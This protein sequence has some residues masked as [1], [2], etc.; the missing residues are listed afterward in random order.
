[1]KPITEEQ[2][3]FLVLFVMDGEYNLQRTCN[4][5]GIRPSVATA[6]FR[7]PAFQKTLKQAQSGKLAA[8][9]YGALL[10]LEDTLA[11]AH[12]DI[13]QVEVAEDGLQALPRHVRVAIKTVEFG[14]IVSPD[15]NSRVYPKKVTMHD[16]AWALQKAGE[17]FQVA[18]QIKN[19]GVQTDDGAK[20][21]GGLVVRPPITPEQAE[22]EELLK[23]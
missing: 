22:A 6:W 1:M 19:G 15:G 20:R 7:D 16:K 18:D 9:G 21:I 3:R 2:R 13:S 17:W 23:E 8:L 14:V 11:I 10:T 12:S 5:L 4:E